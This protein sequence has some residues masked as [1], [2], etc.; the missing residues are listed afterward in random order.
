MQEQHRILKLNALLQKELG[1]IILEQGIEFPEGTI[2]TIINVDSSPDL[3]HSKIYISIVPEARAKEVVATLNRSIFSI[4]QELN[5]KLRMR[6]IPKIEWHTY[7]NA[8]Q[9]KRVDELLEEIKAK[10]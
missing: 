1:K 4:Q 2:V 7:E 6:P 8:D 3:Q 9:V 5:Q 10:K